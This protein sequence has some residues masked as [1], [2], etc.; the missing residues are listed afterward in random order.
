[1]TTI[2]IVVLLIAMIIS[3]GTGLYYLLKKPEPSDSGHNL[4]KALTYRIFFAVILF[5][6]IF[7]SIKMGWIEPSNSVN[8]IKFN[9]E[10]QQR[11][12]NNN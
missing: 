7:L 12:D 4:V 9:Q 1:M 6:F 11:I 10:Q 3:L 2:I 8:P 5:G